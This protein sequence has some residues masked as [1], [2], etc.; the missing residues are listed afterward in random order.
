M[1]FLAHIV[2][3]GTEPEI[4]IGNFL[5]DFVRGT[6]DHPRNAFLS[7]TMKVGAKLHRLIDSFT[8]S[9]PVVRQSIDRLQ[10]RYHKYA[11]I[12]V[13]VY[14]DH[15]LAKSW[16]Q[17]GTGEPLEGFARHFYTILLKAQPTL[18]HEFNN[19]I[20][21]ITTHDWL[22]NYAHLDGIGWSLKGI[23]RRTEHVSG[24]ENALI[25]LRE[26][27]EL[28]EQE[29]LIFFPQV[30]QMSQTFINEAMPALKG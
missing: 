17:F 11:G 19:L 4:Q 13:D 16:Q 15:F 25:E 23:S 28:F 5:G 18:P 6:I 3:S 10:P 26:H 8:D 24:I 1:N 7:P 22:S 2:L 21:S 9:H 12:V 29:F 27:F 14:Y 20:K 30:R